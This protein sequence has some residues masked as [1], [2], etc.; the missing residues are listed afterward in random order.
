MQR[1]FSEADEQ[2]V[3]EEVPDELDVPDV[4][5]ELDVPDVP[6]V[7][8][9]VVPPELEPLSSD[10]AHAPT[11]TATRRTEESEVMRAMF[12]AEG[13]SPSSEV[14]PKSSLRV[15]FWRSSHNYGC[16]SARTRLRSSVLRQARVM[17]ASSAASRRALSPS[18]LRAPSTTVS[19]AR[20]THRATVARWTS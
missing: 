17:L 13:Q 14:A 15:R 18:R 11:E 10:E 12:M 16:S 6:D 19:R 3:V 5:D 7:P 4:P 2:L 20:P 8:P 9:E 1:P